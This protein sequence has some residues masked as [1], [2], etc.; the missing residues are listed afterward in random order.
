MSGHRQCAQCG[1][2]VPDDDSFCGK[3]GAPLAP[4]A[5]PIPNRFDPWAQSAPPQPSPPAPTPEAAGTRAVLV[6]VVAALLIAVAAAALVFVAAAPAD[7]PPLETGQTQLAPTPRTTDCTG[8][9]ALDASGAPISGLVAIGEP[10]TIMSC[11]GPWARVTVTA[12]ETHTSYWTP[13]GDMAP[14]QSSDV[15]LQA[16]VEQQALASGVGCAE[17]DWTVD[18]AGTTYWWYPLLYPPT[19]TLGPCS[20]LAVGQKASGLVVFAVPDAGQARLQYGPLGAPGTLFAV[21]ARDS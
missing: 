5:A 16:R 8:L 17:V 1:A 14:M 9:R 20:D 7:E 18:V 15:F 3:C 13:L 12:V 6:S 10:V 4:A 19:P 2:F 21:L 11:T